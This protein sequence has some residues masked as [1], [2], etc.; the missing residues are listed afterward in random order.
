MQE[1][2]TALMAKADCGFRAA[3]C[4]T[5]NTNNGMDTATTA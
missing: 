3:I 1:S 4:S 5:I 2:I